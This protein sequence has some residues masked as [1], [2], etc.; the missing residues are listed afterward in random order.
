MFGFT[1]GRWIYIPPLVCASSV[2]TSTCTCPRTLF[3][4]GWLLSA[5][6]GRATLR[7]CVCVCVP[8]LLLILFLPLC[9]SIYN[10]L[11]NYRSLHLCFSFYLCFCSHSFA[12]HTQIFK[13]L[14]LTADLRSEGKYWLYWDRGRTWGP[15]MSYFCPPGKSSQL[16]LDS[17]GLILRS[18]RG[19]ILRYLALTPT[20]KPQPRPR[21]RP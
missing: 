6:V 2:H 8:L 18:N 14:I 11:H 15:P 3:I 19:I 1:L 4:T 10:Y 5:L 20:P 12:P 21:P 13:S 9:D 16:N 17:S 7:V